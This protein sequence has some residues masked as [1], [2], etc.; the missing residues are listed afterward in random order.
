MKVRPLPTVT[1]ERAEA[2]LREAAN[3]FENMRGSSHDPFELYNGYL[4]RAAEQLKV[5]SYVLPA[6]DLDR[7]I[8]TPRY[9]MLHGIDP[10][11]KGPVLATLLDLELDEKIR[12]LEEAARSLADDRYQFSHAETIVVPDTN[13]LLHH[14]CSVGNIQWARL[15]PPGARR[16]MVAV[17]LVVIDELDNAKRRSEKNATGTET[18]RTRARRTLS[19]LE[20]FFRDSLTHTMEGS[21]PVTEFV[22]VL[23]D[24]ERPRLLDADYEIID[25]A[26][27]I[28]DLSTTK[29][30]IATADAGMRLRA[31]AAGVEAV[32]P[33]DYESPPPTAAPEL[34]GAQSATE[35]P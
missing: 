25:T 23:G 33:P 11:G 6:V 14:A 5:L 8:T 19:A 28:S 20:D 16:V 29:T 1:G 7:L 17:P 13:V 15:A 2:V 12:A 34:R 35:Q 22:L 10:A 21:R 26:R 3:T 24:P 18:V 4:R 27:A 9:W 30:V 32:E 31:R